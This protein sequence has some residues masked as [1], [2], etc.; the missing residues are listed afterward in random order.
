MFE[1]RNELLRKSSS[2]I[3]KCDEII[4]KLEQDGVDV[5]KSKRLVS[6]LEREI[7]NLKG[8]RRSRYSDEVYSD[9]VELAEFYYSSLVK[10]GRI[11]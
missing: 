5:Y 4:N 8:I 7:D 1:N 6:E 9:L 2:Y 11:I 3:K 10:G